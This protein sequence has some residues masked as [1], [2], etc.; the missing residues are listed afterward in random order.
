VLGDNTTVLID[1][2]SDFFR[3]LKTAR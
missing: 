1:A 2:E 3:Y